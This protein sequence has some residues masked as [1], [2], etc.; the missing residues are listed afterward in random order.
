M[1]SGTIKGLLGAAMVAGFSFSALAEIKENP[2]QVIIDRNPF[3]LRPIPPPPAPPAETNAPAEPPPEIKLTGITTLLGTPKV[4]LQLE[5]KK[6]KKPSFLTMAEGDSEN[7][8]TIVHIDPENLKVRVKNGDAETTLDFKN[9]GVKPS[10]GAV[11]TAGGVPPPGGVMPL[12]VPPIVPTVPGAQAAAANTG[13]AIVAGGTPSAAPGYNP[14]AANPYAGGVP[15]RPVRTDNLAIVAGG[16]GQVYN[17]NPQPTAAPPPTYNRQEAEA[18]MELTRQ[19]LQQQEQAGRVQ[20]GQP[21]AA[22]IPPTALG[23]ALGTTPTPTPTFPNPTG[24]R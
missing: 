14:A 18:I 17:P 11:A 10:A 12:Q 1:K 24:Q 6:T 13:R 23:R 16:G 19:K 9:N 21:P 15:P 20:P 2:Y 3:N 4:F 22:L 7:G 5:D 8:V